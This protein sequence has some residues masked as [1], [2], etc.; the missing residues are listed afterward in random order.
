MVAAGVGESV[1]IV[2]YVIGEGRYEAADFQNGTIDPK[3]LS[4]DFKEDRSDYALQRLGIL[5]GNE[6]RSWLTAYSRENAIM[7][8]VSDPLT[9]GTVGYN[10]GDSFQFAQTLAEAYFLQGF[11]NGE[12]VDE[13]VQT[14]LS[15][16]NQVS[17]SNVVKNPCDADGNCGSIGA[18]ETD[19]RFLACGELDDIAAALEG[20]HPADVVVTRLEANLPVA[21]LDTDLRLEASMDQSEVVGRYEAALKVNPCWDQ[22]DSVS[23]LIHNKPKHRLPPG[24]LVLLTLGAAGIALAM[25]RRIT[26]NESLPTN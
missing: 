1:D 9:G 4:W 12:E 8:A 7:G 26:T 2:L 22:Q 20:M 6:G 13:D 11:D 23:P 25:R 18:G 14:C 10:V 24:A 3:L 21:A 16:L 5:Q 15:A 19:A 17:G